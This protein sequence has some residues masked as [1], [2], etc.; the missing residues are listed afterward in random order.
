MNFKE[1]R[2]KAAEEGFGSLLPAGPYQL[3]IKTTNASPSQKGKAKLG[4]LWVVVGGPSAGQTSW[5][6]ITL[7]P[8]SGKALAFFFRTME[9]LGIPADWIEQLPSANDLSPVA[10]RLLEI[11]ANT[12]F[13]VDVQV[14]VT[15]ARGQYAARTDNEF[16]VKGFA[17]AA[18][19]STGFPA[20]AYQPQ[21]VAAA[22]VPVAV[23]VAPAAAPVA[24]QPMFDPMTGQP[25]N[26]AAPA[27]VPQPVAPTYQIDPATGL[28]ARPGQP[29]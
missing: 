24:P 11:H 18:P 26:Q 1:L 22:P 6:N 28:P 25:L 19:L 21:P 16:R 10:T 20:Q 7:S 12:V 3:Q 2:D 17:S 23:P 14:K 8:E 13:D 4:I 29:F 5:Q 9:S 15:E 27:P